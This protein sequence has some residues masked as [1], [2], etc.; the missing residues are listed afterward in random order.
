MKKTLLILM[1]MLASA[2]VVNAQSLVGKWC[3]T[4]TAD[5]QDF[6]LVLGFEKNGNCFM[7]LS[8]EWDMIED[9]KDVAVFAVLGMPGI[10]H[11]WDDVLKLEMFRD[12]SAVE[13]SY[14]IPGLD[15]SAKKKMDAKIKPELEKLKPVLKKELL[16]LAPDFDF[17]KIVSLTKNSL[18]LADEGGQ[19]ATFL[20]YN[21]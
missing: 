5:G 14:E 16:A 4:F 10:Y 18:K 11:K 13:I 9:N 7:W 8:V 15:P 2:V 17:L 12:R 6:D 3:L 21:E 20:P 19:I 1:L